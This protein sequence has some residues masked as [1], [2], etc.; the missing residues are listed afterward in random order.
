MAPDSRVGTAAAIVTV[1]TLTQD[2]PSSQASVFRKT[3]VNFVC[4]IIT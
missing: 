1:F 3:C 4:V 2:D